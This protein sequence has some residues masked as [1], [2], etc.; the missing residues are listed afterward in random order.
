VSTNLTLS[1]YSLHGV[2]ERFSSN[3]GSKECRLKSRNCDLSAACICVRTL[4][5]AYCSH[6][7]YLRGVLEAGF[8]VTEPRTQKPK[9][10]TVG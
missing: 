3:T 6:C 8:V 2:Y 10:L 9:Y 1:C 4:M 5:L 7:V